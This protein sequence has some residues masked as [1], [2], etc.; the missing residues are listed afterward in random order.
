MTE[1]DAAVEYGAAAPPDGRRAL[2]VGGGLA[3]SAAAWRLHDRGWH[4][5][6]VD[7]EPDPHPTSYLLQLDATAL[8]ILSRMGADD[9]VAQT[10][11]PAPAVAFRWRSRS[12]SRVLPLDNGA[13]GSNGSWR[14]AHRGPFI[15]AL[16]DHVPAGVDKRLGVGLESL[17][18]R[19]DDVLTRLS[20]GTTEL[21]DIV[22]G[23]DGV[24]STVRDLVLSS[25][26]ASV[27]RNGVTHVWVNVAANLPDGRAF[28]AAHDHTFLQLYPYRDGT[29]SVLAAVPVPGTSTS[30]PRQLVQRVSDTIDHLGPD[31][32]AVASAVRTSTQ[33]KLTRF[34]QVRL[35]TWHTRR[36]VLLG[37]SAYCI[38]PLS[39]MGAHASLLGAVTL[40]ES[41]DL[42]DDITTAFATYEAHVRPFCELAQN[43]TARAVEFATCPDGRSR[44]TT[45][46][47]GL[48]EITRALPAAFTRLGRKRLAGVP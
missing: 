43:V 46:V 22:V 34:S 18:N 45:L 41:L 3:G 11:D 15:A 8:G 44:P 24:H 30:D 13:G 5:V 32:A 12:R 27:Y 39:G 10:T 25:A 7:K 17:E 20:D 2:V 47:A 42:T 35:P 16:F 37:D 6:L 28:M 33:V 19:A 40:A 48:G 26:R 23:A 29:T 21:F 14:L 1:P 36:V 9:L 4:V 31:L 38:D